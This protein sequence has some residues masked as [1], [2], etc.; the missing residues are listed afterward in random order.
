VGSVFRRL[1][2][3]LV[4][5]T[6]VA[7]AFMLYRR[8]SRSENVDFAVDDQY[9]QYVVDTN[10]NQSGADAGIIGGVG[11]NTLKMARW[12]DSS[13]DRT[14]R[15]VFGFAE[16]LH[17]NGDQWAIEKPY[18]NV[19]RPDA[20][21]FITADHG[22][23]TVENDADTTSPK[24]ARLQGNVVIRILTKNTGS[25]GDL[26]IYL[27]DISF[28]GE[29]SKFSTDGP[30]RFVS[31]HAFMLGKGLRFVYNG[32]SGRL[33]FLRLTHIESLRFT[34]S[35]RT[36]FA[37][38]SAQANHES[39]KPAHTQPLRKTE[40][41]KGIHYRCL[42]SGNVVIDAPEQLI[43]ARDELAINDI[44]QPQSG[45]QTVAE[46]AAHG[47]NNAVQPAAPN[48]P[49]KTADVTT[50]GR[51]APEF[52]EQPNDIFV[53][54]DNGILIVPSDSDMSVESFDAFKTGHTTRDA[55][56]AVDSR[57]NTERTRLT[58]KKIDYTVSSGDTTAVGPLELVFYPND[59]AVNEVNRPQ[60]STTVPVTVT[61]QKQAVFRAAAN[62]VTLRGD[63]KCVMTRT[64]SNATHQYTLSA[65]VL[66]VDL[67]TG[68]DRTAAAP[69]LELKHITAAGGPV[70]LATVETNGTKRLGAA[71]LKC[72]KFEY[73]TAEQVYMATGPGVIKI[74]NSAI[75]Q[76]NDTQNGYTLKKRCWAMVRD[77]ATLKYYCSTRR[78]VADAEPNKTL[79]IGYVPIVNDKPA[80][81]IVA[82][83][84]H[85][86]ILLQQISQG[87]SELST[88]WAT[89]GITYED[90]DK[91]FAGSE[92]F[93]DNNKTL[94]TVRG[95]R[96][97]PCLFNGVSVDNIEYDLKT[98]RVNAQVMGPGILPI[99][100]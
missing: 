60:K 45:S 44:Y 99:G 7:A 49:T 13:D 63:C 18:M 67:L 17:K 72:S 10:N 42:L 37:H 79:N 94:V 40:Q 77:F 82:T 27:D 33:E 91:S 78:I 19:F 70:H 38:D 35:K 90:Q 46:S 24:D 28:M 21:F 15:R 69:G 20:D 39:R 56:R 89:G 4:S 97:W 50:T 51:L 6:L 30:V 1:L 53:N 23:V 100:Q 64:D 43:F 75:S 73:D 48:E 76:P 41:K 55:I 2:I 9:S 12:T 16:L 26:C 86:E 95:D 74:D 92:L 14:V 3:W 84:A 31:Q 87:R 47:A 36:L 71:E 8:L 83:A 34:N 11:V 68:A 5:L 54:C 96:T 58:A 52:V 80:Q 65:P 85:V 88:L 98:G 32:S 29:Q 57:R 61:A 59:V 93:Y 22:R 62:Q 25:G 81:A 66:T